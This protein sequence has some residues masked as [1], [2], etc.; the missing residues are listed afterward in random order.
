[1]GKKALSVKASDVVNGDIDLSKCDTYLLDRDQ[2]ETDFNYRQLIP[3]IL[4]LNPKN[5]K[6]L[7]YQRG[8]K[9]NE[10]R[11]HSLYS[12]GVGGH[13]EEEANRSDT[14]RVLARSA[15]R[16]LKE[17]INYSC[18]EEDEENILNSLMFDRLV[19]SSDTSD[20]NRVHLGLAIVFIPT[21]PLYDLAEEKDVIKNTTWIC[22]KNIVNQG[23]ELEEWSQLSLE[24]FLPIV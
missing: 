10:T 17:E 18:N 20:V 4:F 22:L 23:L 24:Y 5:G 19:I 1:V 15:V 21:Q 8:N 9:G 13:V 7:V 14:Y 3:Y 6:F 11:L 2:C 12:L 16:E